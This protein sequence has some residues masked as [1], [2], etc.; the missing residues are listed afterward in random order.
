MFGNRRVFWKVRAIPS[1]TTPFS[2]S[3]VIGLPSNRIAPL[4]GLIVPAIMLNS[5]VFPAPLGPMT[6]LICPPG[7]VR[8]TPLTALTP[9]NRRVSARVS[10]IP[11]TRSLLHPLR[12]RGLR[13]GGRP[14]AAP[15]M[16]LQRPD[17]ARQEPLR[18]HDHHQ[19]HD[20]PDDDKPRRRV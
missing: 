18:P 12:L 9:P 1:L 13:G 2:D 16:D 4:V 3:P 11:L 6:P 5:V 19:D 8:L 7:T 14:D 10:S 20:R 17:A 15:P